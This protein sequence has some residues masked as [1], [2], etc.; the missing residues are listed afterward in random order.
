M[1]GTIALASAWNGLGVKKRSAN[2]ND[3]RG[4]VSRV[5]EERRIP[6]SWEGERHQRD[7]RER[8]ARRRAASRRRHAQREPPGLRPRSSC[9]SPTISVST[10]YGS[11]VICISRM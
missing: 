9:P 10:R 11:T 3:C 6:E 1:A 2:A 4:S 8:Q 7:H 5:R